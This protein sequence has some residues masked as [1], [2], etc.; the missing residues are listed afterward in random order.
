MLHNLYAL[1]QVLFFLFLFISPVLLLLSSPIVLRLKKIPVLKEK[2]PSEK[3]SSRKD[4]LLKEKDSSHKTKAAD[5]VII[6]P[7]SVS[8]IKKDTIINRSATYYIAIQKILKENR[9]LN[10]AGKPVAM[11]NQIKN[12]PPGQ[13]F[14]FTR[15]DSI[16]TWFFPFFLYPLF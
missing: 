5:S 14:L 10:S 6:K 9:F 1:K 15:S 4:P 12:E 8:I 7:D 2:I 16:G 3:D 11:V 13:F